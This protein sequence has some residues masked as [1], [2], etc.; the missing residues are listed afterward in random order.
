M[1]AHIFFFGGGVGWTFLH[2]C[3][4]RKFSGYIICMHDMRLWIWIYPW[5]STEAISATTH[6]KK[7]SNETTF[8][9]LSYCPKSDSLH[10]IY[11]VNHKNV[12]F[13]FF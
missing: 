12:F 11:T 5:L 2:C 4:L 3:I 8:Y 9:Y 13:K 1:S 6:S 10:V 7:I